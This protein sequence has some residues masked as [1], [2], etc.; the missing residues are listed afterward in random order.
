MHRTRAREILHPAMDV[1]L[2]PLREATACS[3]SDRADLP[4]ASPHYRETLPVDGGRIDRLDRF[5]YRA[6]A[7]FGTGYTFIAFYPA[8]MISTITAG[9]KYGLAAT[10]ISSFC[11]QFC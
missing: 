6:H 10:L 9:W 7:A 11:R 4:A 3:P 1:G 5:P 8:I 2:P